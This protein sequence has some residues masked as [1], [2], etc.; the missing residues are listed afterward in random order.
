MYEEMTAFIVAFILVLTRVAAFVVVMPVFRREMLPKTVKI[1]LVM[2]LTIFWSHNFQRQTEAEGSLEILTIFA[3]REAIL[4]AALGF[5]LGLLM[6]PIQVAGSWISQELGLS[7]A[8]MADPV[9]QQNSSV[10]AQILSAIATLMFLALNL[11]HYLFAA[12]DASFENVPFGSRLDGARFG[13]VAVES[14]SLGHEQG[15]LIA[16]PVGT[17]LFLSLVALFLLNRASPQLNLFSIG[18]PLRII[19]GLLAI[20]ALLPETCMLIA[21]SLSR[22]TANFF[23]LL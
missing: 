23:E 2:A 17:L 11:H 8:S 9:T 5:L 10:V 21:R 12:L 14:V 6:F 4:G 22:S 7:M 20:L 3:V 13:R 16:A 1:G 15:L 19:G 18:M